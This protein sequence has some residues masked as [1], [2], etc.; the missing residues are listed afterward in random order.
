MANQVHSR[1]RRTL[2]AANRKDNLIALITAKPKCRRMFD[3]VDIETSTRVVTLKQYLYFWQSMH[4]TPSSKVCH[5]CQTS[6]SMTKLLY[7]YASVK[8]HLQRYATDYLS[9]EWIL[10]RR[11][12]HSLTKDVS[13]ENNVPK[14]L[15]ATKK[16]HKYGMQSFRAWDLPLYW[17][18]IITAKNFRF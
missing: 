17:I 1:Y 7:R 16:C 14:Y 2:H 10:V 12:K 3:F 9:R 4:Q 11:E 5:K 6:S 13:N 8:L 18:G 15:Q